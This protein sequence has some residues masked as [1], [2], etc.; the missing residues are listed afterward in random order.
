MEKTQA[1]IDFIKG[2][3]RTAPDATNISKRKV[4][5]NVDE[6]ARMQIDPTATLMAALSNY[7]HKMTHLNDSVES[8][9][10]VAAKSLTEVPSGIDHLRFGKVLQGFR[11]LGEY[12][13]HLPNIPGNANIHIKVLANLTHQRMRKLDSKDFHFGFK[14][15][16][17]LDKFGKFMEEHGAFVISDNEVL[18]GDDRGRPIAVLTINQ[19]N[20]MNKPLDQFTFEL[21]A[22]DEAMFDKLAAIL[23]ETT[24]IRSSMAK[25]STITG[26]GPG[27]LEITEEDLDIETVKMAGNCF[28]PWMMGTS[29]EDYIR[30]FLESDANVLVLYG[31]PGTGKSSM[32][33]TAITKLGLSAL[34]TSNSA[35]ASNPEFLSRLGQKM[36]GENGKY[37]M[38][39]VQDADSLMVSREKGNDA[40]SQLL[41]ATSGISQKLR[42]KLVLTSNQKD[43]SNIDPALLRHGRCFDRM[44]FG[45]LNEK[46]ANAVREYL[47]R[48]PLAMAAGT[49]MTLA[50]VINS[51]IQST[52]SLADEDVQI[53][54]PRFPLRND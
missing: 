43:N 30:D 2:L 4:I 26:V 15:A 39:I 24:E 21:E 17:H 11:S 48:P 53:V 27:G 25:L 50:E 14:D 33:T 1:G 9:V 7:S 13:A 52:K 47:G 18:F 20:T 6:L 32:L 38:V 5:A 8:V 44:L 22:G 31:P 37:D 36:A 10:S 3:T 28:Y 51:D 16:E 34:I 42:F 41:N 12:L 19:N 23:N 45:T 35:V 40:L 29:V 49:R 46:Q 54:K